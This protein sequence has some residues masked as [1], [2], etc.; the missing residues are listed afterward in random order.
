MSTST[1][2]FLE[3]V[4]NTSAQPVIESGQI[5]LFPG[6]KVTASRFR[7]PALLNRRVRVGPEVSA[8]RY[9]QMSDYSSISRT[10]IGDFCT[11]GVRAAVNPF[12][13][14]SDW[15]SVHEFQY[16]SFAF[17]FVEEYREFRRLPRAA[18]TAERLAVGNDVW[19]GNHAIALEGISIGDGAIVGA[20]A[21]V[22]K[23]VP[24]YA[25][26]GGVPA[27]V[28]KY[29]FNDAIIARQLRLKWW[30]LDLAQLSGVSFNDI[31]RSLDEIE[32]I[33]EKGAS[34]QARTDENRDA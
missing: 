29:R 17:D 31:E 27:K 4:E 14:P 22:T 3:A 8:G 20:G 19:L 1:D 32:R 2:V 21:V 6:A 11:I 7:G 25:I 24:P 23:D 9:L 12:S 13:H 15:L 30:E 5:K 34:A 16:H 18:A 28:I 26:V 33:R 10:T